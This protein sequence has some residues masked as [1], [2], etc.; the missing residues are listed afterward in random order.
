MERSSVLPLVISSLQNF[1]LPNQPAVIDADTILFGRDGL[2]DSVALVSFILDVEDAVRTEFGVN[3]TIADERAMS[4]TRSPFRR[5]GS[6]A[7]YVTQLINEQS[8]Q[9]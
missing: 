1:G 4:Q 5:V 6:L 2:L 9:P 8:A 7:D 3:L